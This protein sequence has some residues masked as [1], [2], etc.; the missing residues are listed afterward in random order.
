MND[1][2]TDFRRLAEML[3]QL[4]PDPNARLNYE[5]FSGALVWSDELPLPKEHEA[6]DLNLSCFRGVLRYRTTLILGAPEEKFRPS[7]EKAKALCP[8]WPG[9]LADRQRPDPER[10]AFY[11]KRSVELL[12]AW[13]DLDA[14]FEAQKAKKLERPAVPV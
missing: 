1:R 2:E 13:E 3:N 4:R 11:E 5:L 14:R 7:W 12:Q 6:F 9:F 8:N 10:I